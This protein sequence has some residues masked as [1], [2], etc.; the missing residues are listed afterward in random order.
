[1]RDDIVYIPANFFQM[2]SVK[3]EIG[4]DILLDF[5][6]EKFYPDDVYD[7]ADLKEWAE[8]H[9]YTL[10]DRA[11]KDHKEHKTHWL[12][13]AI[14]SGE[15]TVIDIAELINTWY[16]SDIDELRSLLRP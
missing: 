9:G 6:A 15:A 1:M 12:S 8:C 3:L 16:A 4:K 11:S 10:E 2:S 7:E 13:T 5:I 14:R